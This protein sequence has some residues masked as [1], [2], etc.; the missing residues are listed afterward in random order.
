MKAS[1]PILCVGQLG[2]WRSN[3]LVVV[4]FVFVDLDGW[5]LQLV[6]LIRWAHQDSGSVIRSKL[7]RPIFCLLRLEQDTIVFFCGEFISIVFL[8]KFVPLFAL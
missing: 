5:A 3:L 2:H 1:T 7:H 8:R 4:E 6:L